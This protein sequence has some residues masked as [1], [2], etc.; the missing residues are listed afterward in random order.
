MS[1]SWLGKDMAGVVGL[2][3][4]EGEA[5]LST[6]QGVVWAS[7]SPVSLEVPERL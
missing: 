6:W 1:K 4:G 5:I 2:R 7:L 3:D